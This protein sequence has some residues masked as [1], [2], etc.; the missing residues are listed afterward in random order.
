MK[1]IFTKKDTA[2][3]ITDYPEDMRVGDPVEIVLIPMK[4]SEV[5]ITCPFIYDGTK[6]GNK[7]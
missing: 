3:A 4:D 2:I 7:A 1:Y 6:K 5:Q